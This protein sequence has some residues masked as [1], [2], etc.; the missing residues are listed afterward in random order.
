[1]SVITMSSRARLSRKSI[2]LLAAFTILLSL[3]AQAGFGAGLPGAEAAHITPVTVLDTGG[4]DQV[5][6][7]GGAQFDITGATVGHGEFGFAWDETDLTGNNSSDTCTYF[8]EPD[9]SVTAVCYSVQFEDDGT[10]TSGFPVSYVLACTEAQYSN[11]KCTGNT[12]I[13]TEYSATCTAPSLVDPYF[14]D[15]DDDQDLEASC[16]INELTGDVDG[17]LLLNTCSKASASQ[18][19]LSND[20][21]FSEIPAFLQLTKVVTNNT[22][23]ATDFT[24]TATGTDTISGAGETQL[25]P[26]TP[27]RLFAQRVRPGHLRADKPD[28][29]H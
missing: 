17:L 16:V 8:L 20:C 23:P 28:L 3:L 4:L 26:V 2:A 22:T 25:I 9:G 14:G 24:L 6:T 18:S 15:A 13:S 7:G 21:L 5:D 11:G 1:M 27:G 29:L 10:V 19:S 12:P